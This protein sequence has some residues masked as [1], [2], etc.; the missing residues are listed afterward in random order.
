M[1]LTVHFILDSPIAEQVPASDDL[2]RLSDPSLT[3]GSETPHYGTIEGIS[4]TYLWGCMGPL[5]RMTVPFS[6]YLV[7]VPLYRRD[8]KGDMV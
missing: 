1:V 6:P 4:L 8:S 2:V 3:I 7:V 5:D